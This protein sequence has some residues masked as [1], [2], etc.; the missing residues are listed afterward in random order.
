[1]VTTAQKAALFGLKPAL[2]L[3]FRTGLLDSR[4][5]FTRAST[6]TD[7]DNTG[8][9]V[10]FTSGTPRFGFDPVTKAPLGLLIEEART[11]LFL[12]S[13]LNGTNLSTQTVTVAAVSYALSFYGTGTVALTGGFTGS[14]VGTGAFPTRS[15]L[16]FTSTAVPLVCTVT[17][18]VQY[19]QIEATSTN[20]PGP[21][22]FIPTAGA[23][24]TRSADVASM[25]STNFS[26]WYNQPAGT[27]VVQ[28]TPP[29]DYNQSAYIITAE[30]DNSNAHGINRRDAAT[31]AGKREQ[32]ITLV[33]NTFQAQI[34]T[35]SND[36]GATMKLAYAYAT[37]NFAF[38]KDGLLVGTDSAGTLPTPIQL[39]IG[40]W[41][42][43]AVP[44]NG[45]IGFINYFNTRQPNGRLQQ[46]TS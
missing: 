46:L 6:A 40:N 2:S 31:G 25:T 14:L 20:Y 36:V 5:T 30:A 21:T 24:V 17:G 39:D 18:T 10:S 8:T 7:F 34:V 29:G 37:N 45:H 12:N 22:S 32:G 43:L 41:I 38:A 35:G 13:L 44:Y 27:F 16:V 42:T 15:V 9:I 3:D 19:A 23:T 28:A 33:A 4:I 11:N 1:M 26:S